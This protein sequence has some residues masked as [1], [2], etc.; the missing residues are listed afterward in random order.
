MSET[1]A[2][3]LNVLQS[4]HPDIGLDD[5]EIALEVETPLQHD[6]LRAGQLGTHV[7]RNFSENHEHEPRDLITA[8]ELKH[9]YYFNVRYH[10]GN[11]YFDRIHF[12]KFI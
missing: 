6:N 7:Y 3:G 12:L 2:T 8:K 11:I 9:I 10:Y 4:L 1:T 5:D